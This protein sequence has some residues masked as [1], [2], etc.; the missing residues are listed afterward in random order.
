MI[1]SPPL[2]KP[3]SG[4]ALPPWVI[5]AVLGAVLLLTALVGWH[6]FRAASNPAGPD[7]AVHPGMYNLRDELQKGMAAQPGAKTPPARGSAP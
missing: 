4:S 3:E 6:F 1:Q 2:K 7:L 5:A